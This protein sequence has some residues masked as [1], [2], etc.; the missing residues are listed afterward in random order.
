[1]TEAQAR[2]LKVGARVW[3]VGPNS[4]RLCT[5]IDNNHWVSLSPDG[6]TSR[7]AVAVLYQHAPTQL[8]KCLLPRIPKMGNTYCGPYA[9][10]VCINRGTDHAA[11][12]LRRRQRARLRG[13]GKQPPKRIKIEGTYQQDLVA[14]LLA[15]GKP[16][17]TVSAGKAQTLI[18][19]LQ[20]HPV[21]RRGK[22]VIIGIRGHWLVACR[23]F[24]S[25]NCCR[26][27]LRPEQYRTYAKHHVTSWVVVDPTPEEI[28]VASSQQGDLIKTFNPRP[29]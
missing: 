3:H 25:D 23:G 27:W 12:L 18:R 28:A 17:M 22:P 21:A 8:K 11:Y 10:A 13:A 20:N 14:A 6:H 29:K 2:R 16:A 4:S 7:L 26:T 9:V 19:W 24:V 1:M 5:V 15:F